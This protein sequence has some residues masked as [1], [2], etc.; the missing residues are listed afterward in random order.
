ML[1]NGGRLV[2]STCTLNPIENE[3]VINT[4]LNI[5]D[6]YVRIVDF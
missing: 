4:V 3:A 1:K 5:L 6:N 2:Y